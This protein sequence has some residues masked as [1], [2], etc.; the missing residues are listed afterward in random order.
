LDSGGNRIRFPTG[1]TVFSL[2]H[3]I[4]T[5]SG[6]HLDSY[7][8]G[9]GVFSVMVKRLRREASLSLPSTAHVKS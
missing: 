4:Q 6:A 7:K 9:T 2:L 5:G 3:S 8:I 1:A